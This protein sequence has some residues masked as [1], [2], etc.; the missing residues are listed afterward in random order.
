MFVFIVPLKSARVSNCWQKV[1]KLFERTLRSI[2]QQTNQDF[3]VICVCHEKP[4]IDFF[5]PAISY[6]Q[7]DFPIPYWNKKTFIRAEN[8]NQ[9]VDKGRKMWIGLAKASL[10]NPTHIMFVDADDCIS[11]QLVEFV[12][13]QD[14]QHNGWYFNRG[15]EYEEGKDT[16]FLRQQNF[17]QKCGT[18]YIFRFDLVFPQWIEFEEITR[19]YQRHQMF[20]KY[21]AERGNPLTPLPFPGAIYMTDNQENIWLQKSFFTQVDRPIKEQVKFIAGDFYKKVRSQKLSAKIRQEFGLEPL[22]QKVMQKMI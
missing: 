4:D 12:H 21:L 3:K 16:I 2:C 14:Y 9:C 8:H 10:L 1:C 22:S 5:H 15:Y 19:D 13:Q 18:S 20:G 7:V 11:N 17:N 6:L